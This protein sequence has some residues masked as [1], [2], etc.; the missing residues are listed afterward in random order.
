MAQLTGAQAV[1]ESLRAQGVD[2]VFGIISTHMMDIYDA[3][4]DHRDAI[5]FISARHEHAVALMADGYS[6]VA[7]KPGVCLTSTGPGAA[8]SA[9][10]LGE[11]YLASSAVLNITS[12]AEE[13]LYQRGLGATHETKDQLTML[14]TVTQWAA[15]VSQP[16]EV[17]DRI[18]EAFQAFQVRRPRPIAIEVPVDVQGQRADMEIPR[19]MQAAAPPPDPAAVDQAARMLLGGRR[20][21]VLAG[22]GVHRSGASGELVELA[23]ALG[24]PVFTTP[25]GKAAI[26]EDH[27]MALG[28]Y[29]GLPGGAPTDDPLKAFIDGLDTVLVVGSSLGHSKTRTRGLNLPPNLVHIDIDPE[30]IGKNY[31]TALAVVGDARSVLR[32]VADSVKGK[33]AQ[34]DPRLAQEVRD[35][36]ERIAG[37]WRG[38]IPNQVRVMEVIREVTPRDTVFF[39]DPAYSVH[40]GSNLCLPIYGSGDY[41][42]SLWMG[43]GFAFPASAGAKAA[44][45]DRPVACLTG[46]GGFQFNV[47]ELATCVEYG[48]DPVVVVFNDN[49]WGALKY[50]QETAYGRRYMGSHL[51]NPSFSRLAE[52]YGAEGYEV[53]SLKELGPAL[54]SAL[55]SDTISV[56]D[57]QTPDGIQN[58][59]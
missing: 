7:G 17:P 19:A 28:L 47:Q 8:N 42:T 38:A 37:F 32:Q 55:K 52:A 50:R 3:L 58:F 46:D 40:R 35:L 20:V 30:S 15:H 36:K 14:S 1:I 48:L 10:G 53:G 2:T 11:A 31:H 16:E 45:L 21:G 12:Q 44:R 34:Q 24:L 25:G 41:H 18:Y 13:A 54:E 29:G 51:R 59:T 43:L 39:G 49:A 23:E 26:P 22:G 33:P 5:R 57:V 27:P 56:I 6:R 4:Y 9:G